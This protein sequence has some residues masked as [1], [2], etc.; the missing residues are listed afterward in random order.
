MQIFGAVLDMFLQDI[1]PL[2]IQGNHYA[3]GV[4]KYRIAKASS[5]G[6]CKG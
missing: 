2:P 4:L 3:G 1:E 5:L 6:T